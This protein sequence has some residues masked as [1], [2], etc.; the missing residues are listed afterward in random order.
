[1]K[2]RLISAAVLL[3]IGI[4]VMVGIFTPVFT[5]FIAL[6]SVVAS[7]EIMSVAGV[8]SKLVK[9][10]AMIFSAVIPVYLS[11]K[12]QYV[13][14]DMPDGE[15]LCLYVIFMVAVMLKTNKQTK[16]EQLAI[17]L[18]GSVFVP[19]AFSGALAL[20]DTCST[21]PD[22]YSRSDSVYL[23]LFAL[24][25][26]FFTD[27]FAY[28]VG[29]KFGK[30]KM[31]PV[32]SPKKTVEGAIGGLVLSVAFN[33]AAFA[34]FRELIADKDT[35]ITYAFIAVMSLVLSAISMLGDLS[36]SLLKRNFGIKDFG[37]IMPGH[38]G[39]MDRFDSCIFVLPV[40]SAAIKFM[41]M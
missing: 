19:Y 11:L 32:V 13:H 14:T 37:N 10:P 27:T 23:V 28:F 29:R 35:A 34:V 3:V 26:A 40:L 39:V 30:R 6:L 22:V 41:N 31:A 25:C 9:I 21:Y 5:A 33:V 18:Y 1:M 8:K 20:R 7:G 15:I 12:A 2:T 4:G 16:F 38:G 17:A 24:F 36:A